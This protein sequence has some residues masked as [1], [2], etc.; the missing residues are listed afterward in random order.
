MRDQVF[1]RKTGRIADLLSERLDVDAER[2]LDLLYNSHTYALLANPESDLYLQSDA[3]ILTD[4]LRELES[5]DC[6]ASPA[7]GARQ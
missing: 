2:A 3:Y 7:T 1:W 4:I 6:S 5:G